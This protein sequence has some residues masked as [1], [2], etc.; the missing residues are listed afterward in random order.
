MLHQTDGHWCILQETSASKHP[1]AIAGTVQPANTPDLNP[2]ENLR[3]HLDRVVHATHPHQCNL[4]QLAATL[5]SGWLNIPLDTFRN[6]N[7][8]SS[9][10]SRSSPFCKRWLFCLLTGG[11]I[12]ATTL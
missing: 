12:D 10:T 4:E 11:H 2:I 6:L 8:F 5:E 1:A 9:C 3:D 7:E